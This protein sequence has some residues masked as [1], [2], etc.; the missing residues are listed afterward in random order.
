MKDDLEVAPISQTS[1]RFV[2]RIA[3]YE[4]YHGLAEWGRLHWGALLRMVERTQP[5]FSD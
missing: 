5:D 3:Y 1:L 2:G 4:E